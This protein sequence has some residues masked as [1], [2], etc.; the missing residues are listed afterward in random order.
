MTRDEFVEKVRS[1]VAGHVP[2][3][4]DLSAAHFLADG[5]LLYVP[6]E[7]L[8]HASKLRGLEGADAFWHP[9]LEETRTWVHANV[10]FDEHEHPYVSIR[11]G[12]RVTSGV[13]TPIALSV[14]RL[15]LRIVE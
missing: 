12:P 14:E 13:E 2:E 5:D 15:R 1:G 6:G 8:T 11:L 9:I 4:V 10:L 7:V 3:D